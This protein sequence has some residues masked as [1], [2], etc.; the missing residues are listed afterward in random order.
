MMLGENLNES[1]SC[2]DPVVIYL[3]WIFFPMLICAYLGFLLTQH[4]YPLRDDLYVSN[5][6]LR[7]M[8]LSDGIM[9]HVT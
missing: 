4:L 8:W 5:Q 7:I 3:M 6:L 9:G 1:L 2:V